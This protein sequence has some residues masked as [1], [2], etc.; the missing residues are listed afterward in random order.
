MAIHKGHGGYVKA[1]AN[2]LNI[3]KWTMKKMRDTTEITH[4]GS[5]GWRARKQTLSDSS[6]NFEMPWDSDDT[7]ESGSFDIGA[8]VSLTMALGDSG[9][10]YV[11]PI[12][13][14][15]TNFAV[16]NQ[17]GVVMLTVNWEGNGV[18]VGPS[19]I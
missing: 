18:V 7:P 10:G 16:D 19:T 3:G 11:V 14:K 12:I 5:G 17:N 4:S 2:T 13:V 6:G 1:G 8:E 9:K 15:D